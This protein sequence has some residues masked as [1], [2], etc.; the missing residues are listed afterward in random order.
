MRAGSAPAWAA[1]AFAKAGSSASAIALAAV[2]LSPAASAQTPSAMAPSPL[3]PGNQPDPHIAIFGERYY[4][5]TTGFNCFSSPDLITW[6]KHQTPLDLKTLKWG[7]DKTWIESI[8]PRTWG[9]TAPWAPAAVARNGKYYF[10]FSA[11]HYLGVAVA[12]KPEGPYKDA[13]GKTLFDRW[14]GIDPMAFVDDDGEAYL[15]FGYAGTFG[16]VMAGVLNSD[17]VGWKIPPKLIANNTNGLRNYLEGPFMFKR[18]GIYYLTW[19][20]DNWQTPEY[21]VQYATA[22]HPLGPYTWKGRILEK[23]GNSVGPGHHSILRIPGRDQWYIV[24]HRYNHTQTTANVPRTA[25]IDT[26]RFNEDGTIRK[27]VMTDAGVR[28]VNLAEVLKTAETLR[29]PVGAQ[30]GIPGLRFSCRGGE[31]EVQSGAAA[32]RLELYDAGGKA[33]AARRFRAATRTV[34]AVKA[35]GAYLA[36]IHSAGKT[37]RRAIAAIGP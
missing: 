21:N 1:T 2:L 34:I 20:N 6:T 24:Y 14:D 29:E 22:E 31:I 9:P 33:V 27:V 8:K 35:G 36:V 17:M 15:F 12:D 18:N 32:G 28:G 13:V 3:V 23:D 4:L 30:G 37:Y 25:H 11:D 7:D 16:G 5:Y 26:L 10:Y 19:S